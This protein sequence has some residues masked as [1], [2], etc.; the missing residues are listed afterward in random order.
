MYRWYY[1]IMYAYK[2]IKMSII[3]LN[4]YQITKKKNKQKIIFKNQYN[5]IL[6]T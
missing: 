1:I 4:W 5:I 3:I 2:G 6:I